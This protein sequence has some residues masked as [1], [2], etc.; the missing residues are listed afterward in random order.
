MPRACLGLLP[1]EKRKKRQPKILEKINPRVM[2]EVETFNND[3][4]KL[5]RNTLNKIKM[6]KH[7]H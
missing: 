4:K 3:K 1:D 5:K 2:N 6:I 7:Y